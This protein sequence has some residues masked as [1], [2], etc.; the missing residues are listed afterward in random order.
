MRESLFWIG[1]G[2]ISS[3][4]THFCFN[5]SITGFHLLEETE[6]FKSMNF[7]W[8]NPQFPACEQ[9]AYRSDEYWRCYIQHD[10]I[11][12]Y[13][14]VGTC[15]MGIDDE[16]VVDSKFRVRGG[17]EKLRVVDASIFPQPM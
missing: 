10:T 11:S 14:D 9:F 3:S 8:R 6:P 17:I 15:K 4:F 1:N 16:A 7:T 12:Y 5:I 13:H 2:R